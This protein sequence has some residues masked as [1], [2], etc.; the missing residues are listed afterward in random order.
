MAGK[1]EESINPT[2]KLSCL[3]YTSSDWSDAMEQQALRTEL[4]LSVS[5]GGK[6][7]QYFFLSLIHIL[8]AVSEKRMREVPSGTVGGRTGNA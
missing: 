2:Q 1:A 3:L 4:N 5:G 8:S 7:N 6:A